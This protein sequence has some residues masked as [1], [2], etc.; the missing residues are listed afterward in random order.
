MK[1]NTYRVIQWGTGNVGKHALRGIITRPDYE[2][3]GLKVYSEDKAGRDAGDLV[4]EPA[5]GILAT[6]AVEDILAIDAD[7][8]N[9][10]ALGTTE[11]MY[12][13]PLDD[14]C[15]LL[16]RGYNVTTT[17][18]DSLVYP[19]SAPAEHV[20][21]LEEACAEG[22][23][24]FFGSGIDPGYTHDYFPITL[25]RL[26][27]QVDRVRALEVMNMR[28]YTSQSAM[29]FMGFGQ[30]PSA[31]SKLDAM[32]SD[33]QNSV[34]YTCMLM[35]A[36]ALGFEIEDYRYEREV[37]IT[38][39]PVKIALGTVEPG[40]IAAVKI[41][42]FAS[43]FGRDVL[44]FEFVWRVTDDVRP[45]WGTGAFWEHEI[46]GDPWIHNRLE[47]GTSFDQKRITS[48]TV[49]LTALNG[50]PTVCE[51]PAGVHSVLTLPSWA[52]GFVGP[53]TIAK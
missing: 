13:Q 43:A 32:H 33:P 16:S 45:D 35:V 46:D 6:T 11:D 20:Q 44:Q 24:S 29:D 51:A 30:L 14:I 19:P 2:L 10:N 25:T 48:I 31:P 3:V 42:I 47:A 50:I 12:G 5:T 9:Y 23:T 27:R 52:G 1:R 7:C 39:V 15:M 22:G 28:D 34:F 4:G 18:I 37:G 26:S 8:V 40:T 49:A 17:A 38:D 41:T 36:D 21:R 53:E